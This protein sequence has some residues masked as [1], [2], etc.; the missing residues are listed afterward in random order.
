M[1]EVIRVFQCRLEVGNKSEKMIVFD[2]VYYRL[3]KL[4]KFLKYG[5]DAD[6]TASYALSTIQCFLIM[7]FV[8]FIQILWP[9]EIPSKWYVLPIV[10]FLIIFNW[11]RY[12]KKFDI[13]DFELKWKNENKSIKLM[14]GWI[15]AILS[16]ILILYPLV[17]GY[18]A[19]NLH[20]FDSW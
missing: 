15:T 18:L 8:F 4:F 7:N 5:S 6:L 13:T 19:H 14:R 11:Y 2:Y 1:L 3:Y 17:Y 10:V 20:L 12:E 9:F 16:I